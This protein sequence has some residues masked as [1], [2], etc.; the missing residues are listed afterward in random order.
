M[1]DKEYLTQE[2]YDKLVAELDYLKKTKR[3]EVAELLEYAKSLGDL[4]ENAE[5]HEARETQGVVEDRIN[6]LE[7]ILKNAV[8]ISSHDTDTVGIGSEVTVQRN[9]DK[10]EKVYT[11]VGGEES[12]LS[13][14]K[15]SI[16]SPFGKAAV[17]KKKG[18]TF[19]YDAPAGPVT[20]KIISIK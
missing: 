9:G 17:G 4:S 15:I 12:D 6:K 20:Y 13:Q 5:Y 8:I 10:A 11:I 19:T 2:R 3:R 14:G 1:G 18:E 7:D 16:H